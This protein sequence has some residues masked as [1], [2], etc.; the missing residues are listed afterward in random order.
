M[1]GGTKGSAAATGRARSMQMQHFPFRRANTVRDLPIPF[2]GLEAKK[3]GS[4]FY[5]TSK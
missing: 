2:L 5:L 4:T 1:A 3:L